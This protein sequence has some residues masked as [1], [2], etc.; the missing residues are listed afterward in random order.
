MKNKYL[1][2]SDLDGTLLN[3]HKQISEFTKQTLNSLIDKG[4]DFSVATARSAASAVKILSDLQLKIPIILLNGVGI[5]DVLDHRYLKIEKIETNTAYGI[6]DV[7]EKYNSTGFMYNIVN[8]KLNTYYECLATPYLQEYHDER[9]IKYGKKFKHVSSLTDVIMAGEVIYFTLMGE[10]QYLEMLIDDLKKLPAI[11][12]MLS[13]DV[14]REN[15]WYLEIHSTN[16]S[17]YNAVKYLRDHYG[18]DK[19]IGFG[20]N[21][22]DIPLYKACDEFFAVQN[23]IGE[24]KDIATGV[25]GDNH[26][27]G[28][29]KFIAARESLTRLY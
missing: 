8:G 29:A 24:L 5:Y 17:K 14:Y 15:L 3:G 25:I 9:V 13:S 16:A 18:Y 27:D 22:N 4:I 12:V 19:I 20:D 7:L 23:A 1:Y 26:S 28:V 11:D 6:L 2:I 10:Q 21:F